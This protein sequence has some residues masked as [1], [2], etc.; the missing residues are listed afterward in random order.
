M[1]QEDEVHSF[2]NRFAHR[3]AVKYDPRSTFHYYFFMDRLFKST[4]GLSFSDKMVLDIGSGTGALYDYLVSRHRI[5]G[6]YACDISERMLERSCVPEDHRF[7]G[8]SYQIAFPVKFFDYIFMLG[9]TTYMT[10]EEMKENLRFIGSHLR[11]DGMA[12]ITFTNRHS[13]DHT[14]RV[15]VRRLLGNLGREHDILAQP[16]SLYAYTMD[17]VRQLVEPL[18][19]IVM[20]RYINHTV[21]PI[22]RLLKKTSVKL[23]HYVEHRLTNDRLTS[24]LSSD[25]AIFLEKKRSDGRETNLSLH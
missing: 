20:S 3:Y 22:N 10:E 17:E 13:L 1:Q 16:F 8:K 12:I 4:Y 14:I 19:R 18:F 9:V 6:F 11:N 7:V 23:A 5:V 2:F 15:V 24:V 21:F 25:F